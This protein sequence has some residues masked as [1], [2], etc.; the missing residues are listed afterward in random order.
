[1][2]RLRPARTSAT[3]YPR[4]GAF[5]R[6]RGSPFGDRVVAERLRRVD[7]RRMDCLRSLFRGP[8]TDQAEAEARRMLAFP[9]LTGNHFLAADHGT[10]TR[11]EVYAL[12][13]RLL[14][15]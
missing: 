13:V 5:G 14:R 11:E 9:L 2:D 1:M 8:D 4:P 12:A 6:V 15:A 7:N 10:R 3:G